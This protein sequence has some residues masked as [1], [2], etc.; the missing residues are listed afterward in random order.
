MVFSNLSVQNV[1]TKIKSSLKKEDLIF[2]YQK[3]KVHFLPK[4]SQLSI[5]TLLTFIGFEILKNME[6]CFHSYAK[7]PAY[8]IDFECVKKDNPFY[9]LT[10]CQAYLTYKFTENSFTTYL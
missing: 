4:I 6:N 5:I 1:S 7:V 10:V 8:L 2:S 3:N 9:N